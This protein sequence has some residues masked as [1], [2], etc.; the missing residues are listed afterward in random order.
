MLAQ[1]KPRTYSREEYFALEE[2]SEI[3][4]E[5]HNGEIV[6]MTGG[7]TN[8]NRIAINLV[9]SLKFAL[10]G[11]KIS[12]FTSDVRLG[13]PAHRRYTYPDLQIICGDI[14]YHDRR[15]D[16]VTNPAVIVEVVRDVRV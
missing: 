9:T 2:K 5:Y 7:T 10:R 15:K 11:Q 13:F 12:F 1:T 14:A 16:T 4:H 3:K 8:H 6:P